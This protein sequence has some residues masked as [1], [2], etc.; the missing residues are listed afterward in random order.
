MYSPFGP[1]SGPLILDQI[2]DLPIL[3]FCPNSGLFFA[4][5]GLFQFWTLI[6]DPLIL[7]LFLDSLILDFSILDPLFHFL[8]LNS[9]LFL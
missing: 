7:D 1:N 6:L 5:S 3:D 4:N 8:D 9:G 2:L